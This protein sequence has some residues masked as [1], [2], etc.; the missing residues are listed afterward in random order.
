MSFVRGESRNQT[1]ILIDVSKNIGIDSHNFYY[2]LV[3]HPVMTGTYE[4][5]FVNTNVP[6]V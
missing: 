6:V 3:I 4:P 5:G 1:A 2:E